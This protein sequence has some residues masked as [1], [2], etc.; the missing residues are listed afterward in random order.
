MTVQTGHSVTLDRT[1][2][3]S[4]T[5]ARLSARTST[6]GVFTLISENDRPSLPGCRS[7]WNGIN[8]WF[9]RRPCH[10]LRASR[11]SPAWP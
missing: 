5:S 11:Q 10:S 4:P 9:N 2:Q 7:A 1:I 6:W 3:A 8:G